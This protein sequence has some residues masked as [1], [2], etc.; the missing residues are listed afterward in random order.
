MIVPEVA[1]RLALGQ[2][3]R[4]RLAVVLCQ[5]RLVVE[6]LQMAGATRHA[7]MNHATDSRWMMD[8][9]G[10]VGNCGLHQRCQSDGTD[11]RATKERTTRSWH[12]ADGFRNIEDFMRFPDGI[13]D[14]GQ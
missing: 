6:G 13:D 4:H 1:R 9:R 8:W 14:P 10:R 2:R 3:L 12:S 7:K 11:S 5:F